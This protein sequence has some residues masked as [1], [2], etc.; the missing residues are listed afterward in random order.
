MMNKPP[1]AIVTGASRGIGLAIAKGLAKDGYQLA[2][3]ATS[4]RSI[5]AAKEALASVT[6]QTVFA[7]VVDVSKQASVQGFIQE[8]V[9]TFGGLAVLVNNAGITRDMLAVRMKAAQ[10]QSVLDTNLSSV[11]FASQAALKPMMRARS[12]RIINI[13]SVVASMGN[14]GQTNYCASKGG[15]DAMTRSLAQ[16]VGSRNITVNAIAP[17]FIATDMTAELGDDAQQLLVKQIPL[18]R[19]GKADDIAAA[20]RFLAGAGGCYITGQVL[21]VNGGMYM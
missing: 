21:Q 2:I 7:K 10:W 14:P 20:V 5:G 4:E 1:V 6:D 16:E 12:G 13:S 3:C 18:G 19:M 11:F 15:V 17:G 9:K 8:T